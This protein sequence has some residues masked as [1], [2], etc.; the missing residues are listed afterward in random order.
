MNKLL[1]ASVLLALSTLAAADASRAPTPPTPPHPPIGMPMPQCTKSGGVLF[2][3]KLQAE[4]RPEMNVV[5]EPT[6]TITVHDG[7]AWERHDVDGNGRKAGDSSGC[8]TRDQV[9]QIRTALAKA[10]WTV[11]HADFTCA[12]ISNTFT[13][14]ASQGKQLWASHLCQADFLDPISDKALATISALL[15]KVTEPHLPPCCKH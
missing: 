10:T 14:Y 3:E 9:S 13:A 8:L 12:A 15:A 11:S 4:M 5:N 6:W 2:E 1:T 7:G